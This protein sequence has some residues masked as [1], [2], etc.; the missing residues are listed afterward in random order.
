MGEGF[1]GL[2]LVVIAVFW[3][4]EAIAS[5]RRK[6]RGAQ[7]PELPQE[8]SEGKA[9]PALPTALPGRDVWHDAH[10]P[11]DDYT[12]LPDR[13]TGRP[14][15]AGERSG[16]REEMPGIR[17]RVPEARASESAAGMVHR[18]L[19]EE[20]AALARGERPS[21]VPA[22]PPQPAPDIE[23]AAQPRA[24]PRTVPGMGGQAEAD[25][26]SRKREGHG[27]ASRRRE[28][29]PPQIRRDVVGSD[30][31]MAARVRHTPAMRLPEETRIES[32]GSRSRGAARG[33]AL[34]SILGN[35][36]PRELRR[37]VVVQEILGPPVALR[38][39]EPGTGGGH[40]QG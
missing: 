31:A 21:T 29:A 33:G 18:D 34:R 36:S 3:I 8:P 12:S 9:G 7:E 39:H 13:P 28:V 11:R 4:L 40:P 6:R 10:D 37:A 19:W 32:P 17:D 1:E 27:L 16:H 2:F 26:A 38:T 5:S 14:M 22:P 25:A 30:A 20:L 24:R 23:P 35:Q 15:T